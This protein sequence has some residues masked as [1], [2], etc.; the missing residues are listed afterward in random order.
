MQFHLA[1][2]SFFS[3]TIKLESRKFK[4]FDF[5]V[6][7]PPDVH[8][9]PADPGHALARFHS[10]GIAGQRSSRKEKHAPTRLMLT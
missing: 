4:C 7:A 9:Q 2:N 8:A 5:I 1:D 6:K 10:N 3:R